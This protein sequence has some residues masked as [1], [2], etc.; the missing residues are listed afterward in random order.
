MKNYKTPFNSFIGA[1]FMNEDL[2]D[3][4]IYFYNKNYHLR[5]KAS[6]YKNSR[7]I[8][9]QSVKEGFDL[10]ISNNFI[11]YPFNLYKEN[12]QKC[13]DLYIK[14]Y[15]FLN[16]IDR[17]DINSPYNIQHY[18]I[19]GGFKV[20]HQENS[21]YAPNRVLVFMTYLNDVKDGGTEFYYQ[22]IKTE[23]K[24]GLTLIWPAGL[25]H[26]H[27]G[28]ISNTQEKKIVTGWFEYTKEKKE[29]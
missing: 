25:T 18:P 9:D 14:K 3:E 21:V 29:I 11:C 6:I 12:L 2:C 26:F 15:N 27:R 8:N 19:G 1:W 16:N 4:I 10:E 22:K 7:L 13:L 24:K 20:W 17:F 28:I 23:A 5:T